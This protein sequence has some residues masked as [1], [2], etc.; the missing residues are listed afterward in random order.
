MHT[1]GL[2][3]KTFSPALRKSPSFNVTIAIF[4]HFHLIHGNC[5]DSGIDLVI[6]ASV[7]CLFLLPW[8]REICD[9][10]VQSGANIHLTHGYEKEAS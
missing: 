2:K 1:A 5:A 4:A 8:H 9:V 3:S 7:F 6:V 10:A